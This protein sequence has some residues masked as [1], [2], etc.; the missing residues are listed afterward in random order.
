MRTL[1][2]ILFTENS[3]H[4]I[5]QFVLLL[6]CKERIV[7]STD[8]L[9]LTK[10]VIF[11]T[12]NINFMFG[13]PQDSAITDYTFLLLNFM[14]GVRAESYWDRNSVRLY[15]KFLTSCHIPSSLHFCIR[16]TICNTLIIT[17][18]TA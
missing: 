11:Y 3:M 9:L 7:F 16:I 6:N 15:F 2:I 17:V 5:G 4:V 18:V 8:H 10:H 14:P 1:S 13:S 12:I